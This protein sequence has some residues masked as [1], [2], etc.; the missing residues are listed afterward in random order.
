M[1]KGMLKLDTKDEIFEFYEKYLRH[2]SNS[3]EAKDKAHRIA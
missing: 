1:H 2:T 3:R